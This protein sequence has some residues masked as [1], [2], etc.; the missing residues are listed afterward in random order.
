MQEKCWYTKYL[1]KGY[2]VLRKS[3]TLMGKM[4]IQY[5]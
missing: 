3:E 4:H 2:Y 5:K 1:L